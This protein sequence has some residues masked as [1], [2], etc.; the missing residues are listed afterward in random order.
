[1]VVGQVLNPQGSPELGQPRAPGMA[2]A[3][4]HMGGIPNQRGLSS[5]LEAFK[6]SRLSEIVPLIKVNRVCLLITPTRYT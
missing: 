4:A 3:A 1:M 6:S 2:G 5:A